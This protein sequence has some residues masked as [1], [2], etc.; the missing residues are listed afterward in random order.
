MSE[1]ISPH[2]A[3]LVPLIISMLA[4]YGIVSTELIKDGEKRVSLLEYKVQQIEKRV[5]RIE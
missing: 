1:K 5:E 4:A 3:W 2:L